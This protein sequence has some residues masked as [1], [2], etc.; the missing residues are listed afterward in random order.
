MTMYLSVTSEVK[1]VSDY[2]IIFL[3]LFFYQN[4]KKEHDI[5]FYYQEKANFCF[6]FK[7]YNLFTRKEIESNGNMSHSFML[8]IRL[9]NNVRH[10][11][12]KMKLL[13]PKNI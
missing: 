13:L 7:E 1:E 12:G 2:P 9:T 5:I 10:I 11:V 6:K 8:Q 3:V 4:C